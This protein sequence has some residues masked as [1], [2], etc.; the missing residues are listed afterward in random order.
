M[1]AKPKAYLVERTARL[2]LEFVRFH[3]IKLPQLFEALCHSDQVQFQVSEI[4]GP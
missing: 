1:R 3:H 2:V 4:T